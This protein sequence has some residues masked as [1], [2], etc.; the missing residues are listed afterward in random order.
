MPSKNRVTSA[1]YLKWGKDNVLGKKVIEED[2]T[3]F[4]VKIWCQMICMCQMQTKYS[5]N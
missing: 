4:V 2:A 5:G 3:Q 1:T